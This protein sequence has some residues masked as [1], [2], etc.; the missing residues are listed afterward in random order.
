MTD[1][2]Q[3]VL[4]AT[5]YGQPT[6]RQAD[7]WECIGIAKAVAQA[8]GV[9]WE[10]MIGPQLAPAVVE[11]RMVA[12]YLCTEHGASQTVIAEAM[13]CHPTTVWGS[14]QRMNALL[15]VDD[16]LRAR[17]D[18]ISGMLDDDGP[19]KE[20]SAADVLGML[21]EPAE[22]KAVARWIR[23]R[24]LPVLERGGE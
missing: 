24:L 7:V 17:V 1:H 10:R 8:Y 14:L 18:V 3:R 15:P 9:D 11:A 13:H 6:P 19:A 21:L 2:L 4:D 22:R 20:M 16:A 12:R 5:I 23:A